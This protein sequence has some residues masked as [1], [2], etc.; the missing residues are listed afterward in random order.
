MIVIVTIMLMTRTWAIFDCSR[1]VLI[2][3]ATSYILVIVPTLAYFFVVAGRG[4]LD[5]H[6]FKTI[7]DLA[8]AR[9]QGVEDGWILDTCYSFGAPREL[10]AMLLGSLLYESELAYS[11][12]VLSTID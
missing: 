8:A 10:A 7:A 11:H 2:T 12:E 9:K 6:D 1:R 5:A 4:L 3:L